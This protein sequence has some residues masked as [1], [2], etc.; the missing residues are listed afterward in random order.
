MS[1]RHSDRRDLASAIAAVAA[2]T[3]AHGAL[4]KV[5]LPATALT[6]RQL[7]TL[8]KIGVDSGATMLQGGT[9]LEDD[10][11]SFTQMARIRPAIGEHVLLKW[12]AP[13]R[14]LDRLL[15][16]CAEGVDRFNADT[17]T[18]LTQAH[19]RAKTCEIR[20]PEPGYDY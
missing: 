18:I 1:Q 9:W 15:L 20:I 16:A 11:A 4:T 8:C 10:R 7:T 17:T 2:L 12:T 5:V 14:S 3:H 19:E 6:T 13:I